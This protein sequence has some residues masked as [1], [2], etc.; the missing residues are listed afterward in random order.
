MWLLP[1]VADTV[2]VNRTLEQWLDLQPVDDCPAQYLITLKQYIAV[3]LSLQRGNCTEPQVQP[4]LGYWADATAYFNDPNNYC[5]PPPDADDWNQAF[6]DY[7]NG[8]TL[9]SGGPDHC[10]EQ[11]CNGTP[12]VCDT[13]NAGNFPGVGIALIVIVGVILLLIALLWL[14]IS[15]YNRRVQAAF[16]A[17][18]GYGRMQE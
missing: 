14:W 1:G 2:I 13:Q 3:Y 8:V 10:S 12:C 9:A 16:P 6:D 17:R 4:A 7:A 15:L 11:N 18:S 5:I